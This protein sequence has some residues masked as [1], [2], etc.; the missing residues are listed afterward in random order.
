MLTSTTKPNIL[1]LTFQHSTMSHSLNLVSTSQTR[2]PRL[3]KRLIRRRRIKVRTRITRVT[4]RPI[5]LNATMLLLRLNITNVSQTINQI[6]PNHPRRR[7]T[8]IRTMRTTLLLNPFQNVINLSLIFL[9]VH[10]P[11][12]NNNSVIP[13]RNQRI[14]TINTI[15]NLR[16][17]ITIRSVN[18]Q[19]TRRLR[20]I[21]KLV[22]RRISRL[23]KFTRM[24]L[25]EKRIN[26]RTT[27]RRTTVILRPNSTNR[28]I[29]TITIRLIKV[30]HTLKILSL[31]RLTNIKGHPT[32]GK[33]NRNRLITPLRPTRRHTTI[34]ANISR[35]IRL[36]LL[37]TNSSSQHTTRI[38]HRVITKTQSLTFVNRMSP[39]TLRSILRLRLRRILIN[40]RIPTHTRSTTLKVI[41]SSIIRTNLRF[42]RVNINRRRSLLPS[43]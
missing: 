35:H 11:I 37:I 25:G 21:F 10:L 28:I 41:L 26:I 19:T 5:N 16:L 29:T 17:P 23:T 8:I 22:S 27:R 15:L 34:Q 3:T 18:K 39:I 31:R 30:T 4:R 2:R 7:I 36:T 9:T 20:P 40:R 43:Q 12:Q 24:V 33:T 6:N 1:N 14:V 38:R 32:I 42:I 13:I